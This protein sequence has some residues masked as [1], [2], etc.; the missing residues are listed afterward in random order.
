MLLKTR[1]IV[2]RSIKY[3]DT[4]VIADIYTREEGLRTFIIG[5]VRKQKSNFSPGL[6]QVMSIVDLV[7]YFK[8]DK[9]M[10]RVK[11]MIPA[12]IF[13]GI[14]YDVIK[15]SVGLFMIE[16][17]QKSIRESERNYRL[18]DFLEHS[19]MLLDATPNSLANFPIGFLLR[20][21]SY[22]GFQPERFRDPEEV[23]FDLKEGHFVSNT[24]GHTYFLNESQTDL[25][26]NCLP[27][28]LT[29][30]HEIKIDKSE[31]KQLI[32][33]LIQFY[34]FHVEQLQEVRSLSVL[35][36]ILG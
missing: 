15:S 27:L 18:F 16:V 32:N 26:W 28:D 33:E 30:I 10:H 9:D 35:E 5:G 23:F 24:I 13:S 11:E 29:E 19:F 36:T 14:S 4:S 6:L 1:G 31:R 17:A 12:Q 7:A 20:L 25:L 22:L 3:G 8:V 2:F 21:S 34:R